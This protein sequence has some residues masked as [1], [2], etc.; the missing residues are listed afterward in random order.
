MCF[1][2]KAEAEWWEGH[3]SDLAAG[4]GAGGG[5]IRDPCY[6]AMWNPDRPSQN[7][8]F[9]VFLSIVHLLQKST[10]RRLPRN[11]NKQY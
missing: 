2:R 8:R 6:T 10:D 11:P 4:G 7:T 5:S 1:Q 9:N 3:D